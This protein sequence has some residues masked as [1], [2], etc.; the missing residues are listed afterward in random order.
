MLY[1]PIKA[2]SR[3]EKIECFRRSLNYRIAKRFHNVTKYSALSLLKFFKKKT[4]KYLKQL[5]SFSNPL[6]FSQKNRKRLEKKM[7]ALDSKWID[8]VTTKANTLR[9]DILI[10]TT[11]AGSGHPGGSLSTIDMLTVPIPY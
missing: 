3:K 4:E 10:M 1:L 7:D 9:R 11:K 2:Y 8:E 6:I 5:K